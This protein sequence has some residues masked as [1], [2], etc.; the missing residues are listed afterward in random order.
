MGHTR[1]SPA[2]VS[3]IPGTMNYRKTPPVLRRTQPELVADAGRSRYGRLGTWLAGGGVL[4][5]VASGA[6]MWAHGGVPA[7][8]AV[9]AAVGLAVA[10][11]GAW[12]L[13]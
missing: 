1:K 11:A 13:R 2:P 12:A 4:I 5:V 10:A 9:T 8:V 6:V 7:D 3:S